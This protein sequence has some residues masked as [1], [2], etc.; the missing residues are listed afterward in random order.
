LHALLSIS[1]LK[2]RNDF[3]ELWKFVVEKDLTLTSTILVI[4]GQEVYDK[5]HIASAHRYFIP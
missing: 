2:V 5:G 3:I 4:D 1:F